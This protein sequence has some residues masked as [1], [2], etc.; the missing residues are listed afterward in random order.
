[1]N[2]LILQQEI[3]IV[4]LTPT[5][6]IVNIQEEVMAVSLKKLLKKC[7]EQILLGPAVGFL[8]HYFFNDHINIDKII[9]NL[10]FI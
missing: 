5:V 7:M 9:S 6:L 2:V 8:K 1:M 10:D 3:L 4:K